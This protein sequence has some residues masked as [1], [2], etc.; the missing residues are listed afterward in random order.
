MKILLWTARLIVGTIFILSGLIKANDPHGFSYKLKE[1]FEVFAQDL[2]HRTEMVLTEDGEKL[3]NEPCAESLKDKMYAKEEVRLDESEYA[4]GVPVLLNVF[5][6]FEKNAL[7]MAI[8]ICVLEIALGLSLLHGV[9]LRW[10]AWLLLLLTVFF[11]FLT[12]YSAYYEKV[13]DCGCF[14]DALKLSPWQSFYKDIFLLIFILPLFLKQKE[15]KSWRLA[16]LAASSLG[17]AALCGLVF[18]WWLP[19]LLLGGFHLLF[20]ISRAWKPKNGLHWGMALALIVSTGF[21]LYCASYEPLKDYRAWA[22]GKDIREGA[23]F[24]SDRVEVQMVYVRKSDCLEIRQSTDNWDWFDS[25]FEAT[26]LFWK[27]DQTVLEKG[28][29]PGIKD[30]TLRDPFTGE[31]FKDSL[32]NSKGFALLGVFN[33]LTESSESVILAHKALIPVARNNQVLYLLAAPEFEDILNE[34]KNENQLDIPVCF[35][36]EKALKTI[37]RSNG[38]LVLIQNG[39]VVGKWAARSLPSPEELTA[40]LQP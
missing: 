6:F 19:A 18:D 31:E 17:M 1:Y 5:S 8:F 7:T 15:S 39:K 16:L 40:L 30:I 12:F 14:G 26:H 21:S 11:S 34:Y 28:N 29:E 23:E 24:K 36:D 25:T 22:I 20:E 35:N 4:V 9:Y 27:Q 2:T 38:G 13:T 33:Q 32:F 10:S 37:L 3:K